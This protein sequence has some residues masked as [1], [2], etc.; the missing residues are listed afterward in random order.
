MIENYQPVK[1]LR[2]LIVEDDEDH[3]RLLTKAFSSAVP[4]IY[5]ILCL[6][7]GLEAVQYLFRK[8]KYANQPFLLPNIIL[9]D[10]KMPLMNG[11]EAL[12][13]LK[14]DEKL[15]IIPIIMITTTSTTDDISKALKLGA[16]D[17][18]VKPVDSQLFSHK[19]HKLAA[20]WSTVSDIHTI[21]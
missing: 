9:M 4:A 18:I 21:I 16:N 12:E 6:E 20:Y 14:K 17:F 5:E 11:F 3:T 8:G 1:P 2:V 7:N 13:L 19:I 15:R 10:V